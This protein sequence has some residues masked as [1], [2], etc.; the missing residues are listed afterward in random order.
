LYFYYTVALCKTIKRF[1]LWFYNQPLAHVSFSQTAANLP[2]PK[3]SEI[4]KACKNFQEV[5][6]S[7]SIFSRFGK[8][9]C[10]VWN[11][12]VVYGAV[13]KKITLFFHTLQN[14]EYRRPTLLGPSKKNIDKTNANCLLNVSTVVSSIISLSLVPFFLHHF[15]TNA[16]YTDVCEKNINRWDE[17][18]SYPLV[19]AITSTTQEKQKKS[20][21]SIFFSF[22]IAYVCVFFTIYTNHPKLVYYSNFN[23]PHHLQLWKENHNLCFEKIFFHFWMEF[24]NIFFVFS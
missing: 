16:C 12:K 7:V 1:V 9:R 20:P 13:E 6:Q 5:M 10:N 4:T 3:I 21:L 15:N 19:G 18:I 8:F 11:W 14:N 2:V 22:F 23:S 24:M 17:I